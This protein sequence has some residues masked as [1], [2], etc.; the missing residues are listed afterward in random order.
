VV[1]VQYERLVDEPAAEVQ[2][3]CAFVGVPYEPAMLEEFGKEAARNVGRAETWKRDVGRGVLLNRAGVWRARMS[4]GQ[5]W[6]VGQATR[7]TQRSAGYRYATPAASAA[8]V[9]RALLAEAW[10]RFQE[11]RASTG[12]VGA[13][14]HAGSVLKTLAPA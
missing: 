5:A 12:L 3:L 2:R 7:G 14:R 6:L 1:T 10:V 13:A 9:A 4:P 8:S 11:A